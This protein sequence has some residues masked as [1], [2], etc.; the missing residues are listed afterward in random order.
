MISPYG[1]VLLRVR[2]GERVWVE[3]GIMLGPLRVWCFV[4]GYLHLEGEIAECVLGILLSYE[5]I[6]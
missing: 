5:G 4:A 3:Y 6:A 1:R 2:P